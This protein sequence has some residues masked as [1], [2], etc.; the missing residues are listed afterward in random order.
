MRVHHITPAHSDKN[1]GKAI[2]SLIAG[3]PDSDWV[4]LR[5]IDTMPL[6]HRAFIWQCEEIA[7]RGDFDLVSCMTN[8]LG[9]QYQ[10][11][12]KKLSENWD[13][14]HHINIANERVDQYGSEVEELEQ[15]FLVAGVMML[16]SVKTWQKVGG[17]PEGSMQIG[18]C[19]L[20]YLFSKE[21]QDTG[22]RIGIAP[23][24]YIFHLYRE[25]AKNVR[26][27]YQH[28]L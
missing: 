2:N 5:D 11:H 22:G 12:G 27:Q 14:K 19:F 7:E 23:G 4:C 10:L 1:Y 17:F 26:T 16:F 13:M 18:G 6:N 3:L 9:L 8:R 24:I 28:L 25:W 21:V 15:H 20:D